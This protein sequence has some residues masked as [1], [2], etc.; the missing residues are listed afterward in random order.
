MIRRSAV[1]LCLA[2]LCFQLA[3]SQEKSPNADPDS[4]HWLLPI[5]E[6]QA[7]PDIPDSETALRYSWGDDISSHY[8][9]ERYL[10]ALAKSAP[11]RTKLV[12]YGTSYE[13]RS[14]NYLVISS[15][16][17]IA[18]IDEIQ[19]NNLTIANTRD[20][21]QANSLIQEAP[22]VVWMAYA[23]HGNEISPSD[24]ALIT[25]YHLLADQRAETAE[26]LS[27]LVVVIDPLQNP[28]GRDRFV[29]VFRESRGLFQQSYPSAN[30]HTER[31]P[32]GR[33]NHYWFDMNRDWFRH[34]QQEVKSKVA[35]YLSW[36]PQMYVDAHEMGRN[37]S[38]YFPP[39]TEPKNPY[40]LSSQHD[41]FAKLGKSQASW[42]DQYGFGYM[43]REVFDA[44]YPGY[45]S[46]WPT[47]QGGLGILWE[48]ASAR[49]A[50]IDRDDETQLTYHDGV[51]N[52][53]I[54]GLA[55]LEFAAA[56]HTQL[57]SHFRLAR[58]SAI[59]LGET[60]KVKHYFL[61]TERPQR[62][63][64]LAAMLAR[65]GIEVNK[66]SNSMQLNCTD[67]RTGTE[68]RRTI[69][70]G[71]FH[72]PVAQPNARLIRAL[73]DRRVEM[74]EKFL[75]RQL[76]R[77]ELRLPDEIYDVTAWSMPLAFDVRC[78]ATGETTDPES[79]AWTVDEEAPQI[80]LAP[81]KVA[82]LI[83]P[84][85]GAIQATSH[86]I[87]SGIRVHVC[88]ETFRLAGRDFERGTLI[89]KVP[90]NPDN[91]HARIQ[92]VASDYRLEVISTD[93]AYV[94]EG[95]HFGGPHVHWVKPPKVLLVVNQP[96][97][98]SSGHTWYLFDQ[99]LKYPTTRVKGEDF[100]RVDLSKFDTIVLPDGNYSER[101]GFGES[102]SEELA[103]WVS[104]GGT[105]ITLRGATRWAAEE[106]IQLI[107]NQPVQRKTK[108]PTR[109]SDSDDTPEKPEKVTPDNVPGA[110]FRANVFQKHWVTAGYAP[111][112]DVFYTG[113][114][115][116]SPTRETEGRT[117]VRF[118]QR[119][120]LL[121]SG[122]C[123]PT[124]LDLL[125]ETPYVVYRSRGRGQVIAFADDPNFRAMYPSLQRL[126]I[127]AALFGASH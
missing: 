108:L 58:T 98:Y 52:H 73:L 77:N 85:D 126:F 31:W 66:L 96:T 42:F 1:A 36:Q 72:I 50:I 81:A 116:L 113:R 122:F 46:E 25:A 90:G 74:D 61:T 2:L 76:E 53:Y 39:P 44:F 37:S 13:G 14:L 18:R 68:R 9:I 80:D 48:Q 127:N 115:V 97:N 59:Q 6:L 60:G 95:A 91:L 69:P 21:A 32:S 120:S 28:D 99:V 34:S 70:A 38:F 4:R 106:D 54:S 109:T 41:W 63:T 11:E 29:N 30:E 65:N 22:L 55:T 51:R 8:Q 24:A 84:T 94:E 114:L 101:N 104:A 111:D 43:T 57:L 12:Q 100:G 26:L 45:G 82:Y 67:I 123:W 88:D 119:D 64:R 93:T 125:A 105:L 19:A 17:N 56:N 23:V 124:S 40:L 5:P 7:D 83:P 27:K 10:R 112:L 47:L 75:R 103:R 20:N 89:V 92:K 110:F 3:V 107:R 87:Q 86:L 49:G 117:L 33:S 79:V 71:S 15:P 118:G 102:R 35:A 78:L 121:S 16:E 62:S